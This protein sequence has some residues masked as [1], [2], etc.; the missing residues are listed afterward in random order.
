MAGS[1]ELVYKPL[2]DG[3]Y[4]QII[5]HF[6]RVNLE[7]GSWISG[8]S[9]RKVWFDL[10]W[11]DQDVD[12]FFNSR[13]AFDDMTSEISRRYENSV[14]SV[15]LLGYNDLDPIKKSS[16]HMS[17]Y[18]TDNANTYTFERFG[19]IDASGKETANL[20][21]RFKMQAIKKYFPSSLEELFGTFDFT[22][23]QF[24]T[25]GNTMVATRSALEDCEHN[26]LTMVPDTTRRISVLR[27]AKY[28]A[29]GFNP[30]DDL[31]KGAISAMA[32]DEP[33]GELDEY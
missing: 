12:Y 31:M 22:V 13:A 25:D 7:E 27:L 23:C 2:P 11:M 5:Q 33:L 30:N 20:E 26:R 1:S 14:G 29:Y 10:P 8:G 4:K 3:T 28:S 17:C 19:L 16:T 18:S 24:A 6:G 9:V 21:M 32:N 15:S